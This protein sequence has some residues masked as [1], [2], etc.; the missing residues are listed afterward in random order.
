LSSLAAE[1][2]I[3]K[4]IPAKAIAKYE[5]APSKPNPITV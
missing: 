3:G 1:G 2:A 4:D 5:I